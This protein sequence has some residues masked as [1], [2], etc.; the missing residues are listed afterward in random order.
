MKYKYITKKYRVSRQ[1]Y[2]YHWLTPKEWIERDGYSGFIIYNIASFGIMLLITPLLN[3][4]YKNKK[5]W[6]EVWEEV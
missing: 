3:R 4:Y 5:R 6:K 2:N 1:Y